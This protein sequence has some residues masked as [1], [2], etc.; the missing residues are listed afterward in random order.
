MSIAGSM[1]RQAREKAAARLTQ[2]VID[3]VLVNRFGTLSGI[4]ASTA[5]GVATDGAAG[6]WVPKDAIHRAGHKPVPL[7]HA[8]LLAVTPSTIH[9]FTVR[10]IMGRLKLKN[11]TGVFERAG[12]QLGLEN[13]PLVTVFR[14]F[15]PSQGQDM[16]F[17]IMASDYASQFAA[18][19]GG[20]GPGP[21]GGG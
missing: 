17:E 6:A 2:P 8:F 10:M 12:L 20:S 18:L 5:I 3:A 19:L 9:V 1:I 15:S 4:L 21:S 7:P 16:T 13:T 14:L 11:E